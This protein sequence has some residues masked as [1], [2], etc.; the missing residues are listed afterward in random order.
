MQRWKF[1]IDGLESHVSLVRYRVCGSMTFR[2]AAIVLS[3]PAAGLS[4]LEHSQAP[5]A[6]RR[7]G[8]LFCEPDGRAGAG[9]VCAGN[10]QDPC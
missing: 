10:Q 4:A 1:Q 3:G 7:N 9:V 6:A 8:S 2:L 5:H